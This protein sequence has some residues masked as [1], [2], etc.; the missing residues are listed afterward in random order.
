VIVPVSF[1]GVTSQLVSHKLSRK[2]LGWIVIGKT[3]KTD[4]WI[5]DITAQSFTVHVDNNT[6]LNLFVF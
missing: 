5:T 2:P 1:V 6:E 4:V 3:T